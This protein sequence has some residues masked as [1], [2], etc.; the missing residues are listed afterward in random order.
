MASELS[1]GR[2]LP[3][4]D[5]PDLAFVEILARS[6]SDAPGPRRLPGDPYQWFLLLTEMLGLDGSA[7]SSAVGFSA[8]W[9]INEADWEVRGDGRLRFHVQVS[10]DG[11]VTASHF[12]TAFLQSVS[13]VLLRTPFCV[14]DEM[15]LQLPPGACSTGLGDAIPLVGWNDGVGEIKSRDASPRTRLRLRLD[16]AEGGAIT[17]VAAR[18]RMAYADLSIGQLTL[19]DAPDCDLAVEVSADLRFITPVLNLWL[20]CLGHPRGVRVSLLA[21]G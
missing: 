11:V 20:Q 8:L 12:V 13:Q 2:Y 10:V 17:S 3:I 19:T 1:W 15:L 16:E 21:G 7:A 18:G 5:V 14:I 6:A 9:G 4:Q